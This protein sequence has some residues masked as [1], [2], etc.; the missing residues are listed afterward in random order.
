[1]EHGGKH[2]TKA[3]HPRTVIRKLAQGE[4]LLNEGNEIVR[5]VANRDHPVDRG[6]AGATNMAG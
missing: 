1:M 5:S 6:T 2:E 4:K 3:P